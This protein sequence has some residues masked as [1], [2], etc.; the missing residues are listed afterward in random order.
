MFKK[1]GKKVLPIIMATLVLSSM[2]MVSTAAVEVATEDA[3]VMSESTVNTYVNE[4]TGVKFESDSISF[5]EE[6]TLVVDVSATP[7]ATP[8]VC[9]KMYEVSVYTDEN[10]SVDFSKNSVTAYLPC[11]LENCYVI[12]TGTEEDA[13][14]VQLE[15]EYVDG[16]YKVQMVGSGSYIIADYALAEGE[17][18]LLE[19]TLVDETTGVRVSGLMPTDSKLIVF[20]VNKLF[21]DLF[22]DLLEGENTGTMKDTDGYVISLV[23]N[24]KPIEIENEVTIT[25]P[26]EL[27]GCQVRY[28][29][30]FDETDTEYEEIEKE[31]ENPTISDE[32]LAAKMN[33]YTDKASPL[34]DSEYVDGSYI[35]KNGSLGTFMIAPEELFYETAESVKA[36]REEYKSEQEETTETPTEAPT[37]APT[38]TPTQ[39]ATQTSTQA[40]TQT[41]T[42]TSTQA[43]TQASSTQGKSSVDTGDSTNL[44]ALLMVLSAATATIFTFRKKRLSK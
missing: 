10:S 15:A 6:N 25:L 26:S 22:G 36:L 27:E 16:C 2:G 17:G 14:P 31:L 12:F 3:T 35:V 41:S 24:F 38:E 9:E 4:D 30:D 5:N 18:E 34:L 7:L 37:Q 21:E 13:K 40:P 20:N 1:L 39:V 43:S 42:Q 44:P 29:M 33:A 8:N 32:E 11:E 23:R 19:Q 28:M